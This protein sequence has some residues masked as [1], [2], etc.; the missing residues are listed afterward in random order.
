MLIQPTQHFFEAP[1]PKAAAGTHK[2]A[3]YEWGDAHSPA[4]LCIHGLTRNARDFDYIANA[5]ASDY[6]IIAVDV[7]GRGASDWFTD[8]RWYE[9]GVYMQDILALVEHLQLQKFDWIG[10][11]MGGIIGMMVAA[12]VPGKITRF[13]INDI[14]A[15]IPKTGL[16]RIGQ[17]VGKKNNFST[18]DDA[19]RYL[20]MI[21]EPFGIKHS[22]HWDH[23]LKYTLVP[24]ADGSVR[25][26][27]DP[28]IG[29]AFRAAA[30]AA[31]GITDIELW[32]L[33]EII[34]IPVLILR[35]TASDILSRETAVKMCEN[36]PNAT[37]VEFANIGHAPTLMED[38]QIQ[39]VKNWLLENPLRGI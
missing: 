38:D 12:L 2:I 19:D 18:V 17:Y 6:R 23:I 7:A 21:M 37:L 11:S 25:L 10:T 35:G 29:D 33:W 26:A 1:N 30:E 24:Q 8:L 5:L 4:I 16:E 9:N 22:S 39:T 20:R 13:I 36:R 14:G 3:W 27:Y 32:K 15:L 28:A 34:T 31:G